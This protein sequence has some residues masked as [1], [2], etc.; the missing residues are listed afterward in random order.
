MKKGIIIGIGL[1]VLGF[2]LWS[3]YNVDTKKLGTAGTQFGSGVSSS[4]TAK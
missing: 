2:F 4:V 1:A 3:N